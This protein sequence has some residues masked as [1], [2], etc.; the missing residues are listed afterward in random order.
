M[1][2]SVESK[3]ALPA[4]ESS[5]PSRPPNTAAAFVSAIVPGVGQFMLRE[6]VAGAVYLVLFALWVLLFFPPFR[7]PRSSPG[8]ISLILGGLLIS[9]LASCHAL[10]SQS[11]GRHPSR[12]I[13]LLG[14]LP[15]AVVTP[16]VLQGIFLRFGGFRP[17]HIPSTS[18]ERTIQQGDLVMADM[19]F[20]RHRPP[21]DGEIIL[22]KSPETPG[23]ILVKRLIAN[24]G[25]TIMSLHGTVS[26]NGV[27]LSEPYVEHTGDAPDELMSFGPLTVPQHKLFF[28]GDN[29]D[30]SLDSRM[31]EFGLV[32]ESAILGKPLY[33]ITPGHDRAGERLR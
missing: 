2:E 22:F 26:V 11:E 20:Y 27:A 31:P 29:R 19:W 17:F 16:L 32:D 30:V 23:I 5:L 25:D 7:L 10:R 4:T 6:I 21:T 3:P 28:M 33:I 13:W 14:T 18:M 8:W 9:I 15:I 24:G 12:W 1:E